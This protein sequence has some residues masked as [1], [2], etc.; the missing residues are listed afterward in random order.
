MSGLIGVIHL[1]PLPGSPRFAGRVDTLVDG[2]IRDAEALSAAAFDGVIIENFGDAPFFPDAV[3][4]VTVA[5]MTRCAIAVRNAAPELRLGVNVLRNDVVAA[6]SISAA[7]GGAAM[8]RANVHV[9]ARVTD[10]GIIEGRAHE[11][12]RLRRELGLTK[13]ELWCDVDVKHSAALEGRPRS[14]FEMT[15]ETLGRGLAD[16]VLVTGEGTGS[17]VDDQVVAAALHAADG[18]PVYA[19]SGVSPEALEVLM[20]PRDGHRL[21]G[22]IVGSW[23]RKDG[24]AGGPIDPDRA[25]RFAAAYRRVGS[26]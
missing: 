25:L 5:A 3:P 6:L 7:L 17:S 23:L 8:V 12:L 14:V 15:R 10:Q 22:V 21:T 2:V 11:T 9:A 26:L 13:T 1:P 18:A 16:A 4:P 20:R 24:K 19:A